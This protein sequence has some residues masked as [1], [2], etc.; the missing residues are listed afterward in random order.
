MKAGDQVKLKVDINRGAERFKKGDLLTLKMVVRRNDAASLA[1]F[2]NGNRLWIVQETNVSFWEDEL[3]LLINT[4]SL[5]DRD[6]FGN[7]TVIVSNGDRVII[8][9]GEFQGTIGVVKYWDDKGILRVRAVANNMLFVVSH[10]NVRLWTDKDDDINFKFQKLFAI[11]NT[12]T[13][14][15][16]LRKKENFIKAL[17]DK[18]LDNIKQVRF[19]HDR[20][21]YHEEFSKKDIKV[22][23]KIW[24]IENKS[25]TFYLDPKWVYDGNIPTGYKSKYT[26]IEYRTFMNYQP[27]GM[28]H[29]VI[30]SM[31]ST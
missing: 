29:A 10:E 30:H 6:A 7:E 1:S 19:F 17:I 28:A 20:F 3:E 13:A 14:S 23:N 24:K 9:I 5:I 25:V 8:K 26:E 22:L 16:E 12:N 31:S 15:L 27:S 4:V 21:L 18:H 2:P 11:M